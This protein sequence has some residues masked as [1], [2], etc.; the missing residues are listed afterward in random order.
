M[1]MCIGKLIHEFTYTSICL[2]FLIREH[3]TY[4]NKK[5]G[6]GIQKAGLG[7]PEGRAGGSRRRGWGIQKAGLG[8]PE[9]GGVCCCFVKG[10]TLL[11][12]S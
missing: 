5:A 2:F 6:L 11:D 4:E 12:Y 7:D 8:D 3:T 10:D 1:Y 9:M